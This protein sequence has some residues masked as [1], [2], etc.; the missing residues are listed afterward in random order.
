MCVYT[1]NSDQYNKL[2]KLN[3][4]ASLSQ[5]ASLHVSCGPVEEAAC[6]ISGVMSEVP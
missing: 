5:K 6:G 2:Y 1:M 3:K 4:V